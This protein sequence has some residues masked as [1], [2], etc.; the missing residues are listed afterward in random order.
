[1]FWDLSVEEMWARDAEELYGGL[2]NLGRAMSPAIEVVVMNHVD[3]SSPIVVE[4]DNIVPALLARPQVRMRS[5][6]GRIAAVF[7]IEPE[8]EAFLAN[9]LARGGWSSLDQAPT[10]MS[11]QIR[12]KWLY[13]QWLAEEARRYGLPIVEPRPWETLAERL[14]AAADGKPH[15]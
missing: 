5:T 3:Q 13:A 15:R 10:W 11:T 4:G 14:L 9:F 1:M 12:A 6:G 8:E 2:I 7:L